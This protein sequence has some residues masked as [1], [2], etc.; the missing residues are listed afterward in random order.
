VKKT[1]QGMQDKSKQKFEVIGK[2]ELVVEVPLPLVEVWEELQA[3][4]EQLTGEAG[5]RI[6]GTILEN[7]V[8]RR[9]GPPHRPAP[10]AG[11]VRWGHQPGY[12]VFGGRKVSVERPRV[13]TREGQEVEL[14]SYAR[15]QH[16]GRRQRAVREGIVAGLSSRNYRRVVESVVEGYGIEKSSVSREF[17]QA[18]AA[19]LQELCEKKLAGL[20]LVAIFIDGIHLGKQVL[21]VALGL[22]ITGQKHVLGLWQG[23][24]EN[25]TVVKE[26]LEEL[27][28]RGLDPERR[29]LFVI[30]GAKA[31]RTG[32]ERVFGQR[33]EVQRCQI[34]KRRNVAE[35][36]AKNAQGDYDRRIRNA[37]AMTDYAAAK[38]E[39][40]KIFRQLERINPSAAR[41]LEEGM[42]ETLTVHRLGVGWLLRR[43]LAS[44]NPIESCL[45]TV[46]KVARNVKR[47]REGEQA[48]RWTATGLLEAQ[49]KFRRVKGYRELERLHRRMNPSLTQQA[50]VA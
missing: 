14:D 30:D 41:S 33:A 35:H 4:V 27:V 44:T 3:Q 24:T 28:A 19:Q 12:V 31:L 42:E 37:Y 18:S 34:H 10:T 46:E 47:W 6:I 20:D 25:T 22:E 2:R 26:L 5:L 16:D 11:A 48:L 9:V 38:A 17:V 40:E 50:Q 8:N 39:L 36:L 23:A 13:R 21:V 43:T 15:L 45:S 1:Y 49:K 7:E 32:I 29:Y